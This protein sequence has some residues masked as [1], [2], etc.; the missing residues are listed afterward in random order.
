MNNAASVYELT[1]LYC[2]SPLTYSKPVQREP[3]GFFTNIE[4]AEDFLRSGVERGQVGWFAIEADYVVLGYRVAEWMLD[5]ARTLRRLRHY[6]PDGHYRGDEPMD[7][8]PQPWAGRPLETCRFKVGDILQLVAYDKVEVGIV[9]ALPLSLEQADKINAH[10]NFK[11]IPVDQFEDRYFVWLGA[12]E[13][14]HAA[15]GSLCA[16]MATVDEALVQALHARLTPPP[17]NI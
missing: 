10:S 15:E 3:L 13:H 4:R 5:G 2:E 7:E 11:G 9:A 14:A 12:G 16:P 17:N 6:D 8:E 1:V